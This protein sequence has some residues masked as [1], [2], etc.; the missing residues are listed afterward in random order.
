VRCGAATGR[1]WGLANIAV[2]VGRRPFLA[3]FEAPWIESRRA[4]LRALLVRALA[5]L[6]QVSRVNREPSLA[7]QYTSEIL[8]L[9]PFRETA[10][11][12]LMRLHAASGNR[13]EALRVF[14]RCRELLRDE[15]GASPSPRTEAVFLE[16]LRE[17]ST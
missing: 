1:A 14:A 4:A 5:C 15:L 13:A 7:I 10:Y 3:D 8:D 9:E 17:G 16:I 11:Q 2:T 12:E 6:A